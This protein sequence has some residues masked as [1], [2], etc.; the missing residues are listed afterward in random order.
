MVY[1]DEIDAV[2]G[3]GPATPPPA[4]ASRRSTSSWPRWTASP[5]TPRSRSWSSPPPTGW[6]TSTRPW[7]A[8]DASTAR[9]PSACPG[10]E[11]RREILDVHL[12]GRPLAPGTDAAAIA[13]FTV[14]MAGAD[15]AALC[16]EASFEAA[17]A[18]D[19]RALHPALPPGPHAPRGGPRAARAGCSP[20]TSGRSWPTTRWATR[21][22]ATCRRAAI[23]LERVTVIPQGQA[24]GITVALPTE[25]RFLATRGECVERLAM[26]M[27]GRAAEELVF[28]EFTSGAADDLNRAAALARRMVGELGMGASTTSESLTLALPGAEAP[29]A[30]ERI[31][32]AAR[33]LVEEAFDTATR[34]L[35]RQRP[36]PPRVRQGPRP[37]RGPGAGRPHHPPGSPQGGTAPRPPGDPAPRPR[38]RPPRHWRDAPIWRIPPTPSV[39][40]PA[41][42][43]PTQAH[44]RG[45]PGGQGSI[46]GSMAR[47]LYKARGMGSRPPCAICMGP[48]HGE[49]EEVRLPSGAEGLALRRA[50]LARVLHEPG[51]A[52][53]RG[54]PLGRLGG[55]GLPDGGPGAGAGR[56]PSPDRPAG[57]G[58]EAGLL[59][60]AHPPA[61]G[62]GAVRD[63][64]AARA[65]HRGAP[66]PARAPMRQGPSVRTMQ[67]WFSEGRWLTDGSR[68]VRAGGGRP[69]GSPGAESGRRSYRA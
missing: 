30:T 62:R 64:R 17:R 31:E 44:P 38:G 57:S 49:R 22:S 65:G 3:A 63:R 20:R 18:G 39:V 11:A 15:L 21:S 6:P 26:M 27:A 1:I 56:P 34:L 45:D 41:R 2:A 50:S 42:A 4:S 59:C 35:E 10:R 24:L 5:T 43:R 32:A 37:G 16:N 9:S 48:G 69:S 8:P 47:S 46:L 60:V 66:A 29:D 58:S 12:R 53:L 68:P 52:G 40:S 51:G 7:S 36:P 25:D 54:Q 14:G 67:R 13:A 55:G 61:G 23:P 33:A 19:R 28:G